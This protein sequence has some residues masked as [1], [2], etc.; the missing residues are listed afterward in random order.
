[1]FHCATCGFSPQLPLHQ[2]ACHCGHE[3]A[4]GEVLVKRHSRWTLRDVVSFF[5]LTA[6]GF[7]GMYLVLARLA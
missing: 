5:S 4:G 7:S 6:V 1:M 2:A 3:G